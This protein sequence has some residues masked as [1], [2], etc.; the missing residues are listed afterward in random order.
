MTKISGTVLAAAA[1]LFFCGG[2]GAADSVLLARNI[3]VKSEIKI[4]ASGLAAP[5]TSQINAEARENSDFD[6][7]SVTDP[8]YREGS[9]EFLKQVSRHDVIK[10]DV[11]KP[12]R[13]ELRDAPISKKNPVVVPVDP[14]KDIPSVKKARGKKPVHSDPVR[15]KNTL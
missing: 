6:A 5:A 14:V 12:A 11:K 8:L 7:L 15:I 4:Q 2:A 1:V 10:S 13:P 9:K 3:P